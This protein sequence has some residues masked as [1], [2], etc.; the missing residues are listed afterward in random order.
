MFDKFLVLAFVLLILLL[1]AML[2]L[3]PPDRAVLHDEL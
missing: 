1:L 2:L 3:G